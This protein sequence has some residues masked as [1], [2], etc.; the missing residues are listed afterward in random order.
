M[1][2]QDWEPPIYT[3][4][5]FL[6]RMGCPPRKLLGHFL[7]LDLP[8]LSLTPSGTACPAAGPSFLI[9]HLASGPLLPPVL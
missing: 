5:I 8:G 1:R 7:Y 3:A 2:G 6:L 9:S 4:C